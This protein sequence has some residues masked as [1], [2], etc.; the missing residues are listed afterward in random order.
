MSRGEGEGGGAFEIYS[1]WGPDTIPITSVSPPRVRGHLEVLEKPLVMDGYYVCEFQETLPSLGKSLLEVVV[2]AEEFSG[3]DGE[4][5][6]FRRIRTR[7]L[8]SLGDFDRCPCFPDVGAV[9]VDEG[10]VDVEE[11]TFTLRVEI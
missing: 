3:K 7:E 2:V 1:L 8:H 4:E 11:V 5:G 10:T 9:V 6:Y